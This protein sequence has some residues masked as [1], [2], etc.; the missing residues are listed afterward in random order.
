MV[1]GFL[2]NTDSPFVLKQSG[3]TCA[4]TCLL[5]YYYYYCSIF[6]LSY[7]FEMQRSNQNRSTYALIYSPHSRVHWFLCMSLIRSNDH[8]WW[9]SP[10]VQVGMMGYVV[11]WFPFNRHHDAVPSDDDESGLLRWMKWTASRALQD[12]LETHCTGGV[13][14]GEIKEQVEL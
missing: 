5:Y 12:T 4:S 9:M 8:R 6:L 11:G 7:P 2:L 3:A 14:I 1:R 13:V 10:H